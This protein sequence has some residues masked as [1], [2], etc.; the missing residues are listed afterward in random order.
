MSLNWGTYWHKSEK[1]LKQAWLITL[2]V[3]AAYIGL[4]QPFESARGI[5]EQKATGLASA[6]PSWWSPHSV[7]LR[8][9]G[10]LGGDPEF[11]FG[12]EDKSVMR[13]VISTSSLDLL[14]SDP[15]KVAAEVGRLAVSSGGYCV[16]SQTN[17]WQENAAAT[18]A[19]RVP[20][21]RFE[22]TRDLIKKLA[23]RIES[24]HIEARDVTK[25]YVDRQARLRNLQ[26]EEEQYRSILKQASNLKD[27]LA[28][29]EKL[30]EVR[31]QIE[32]DQ[33]EFAT[34]SKQTET[35]L[36]TVTLGAEDQAKVFGFHWRPLYEFKL[37]AREGLD[38]MTN[39]LAAMTRLVF[40]LP[41]TLLWLFT[42]LGGAAVGWKILRRVGRAFFGW[43]P[44]A[45]AR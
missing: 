7:A 24:E 41:S 37:A 14:V 26:A 10:T 29:T 9:E 43:K 22:Q 36:L 33:A 19:I 39:Y 23:V 6:E 13:K 38:G 31:G 27:I 25:E 18:I 3:F 4:L 44:A 42:F 8:A 16:S 1:P 32:S 17:G 2:G 35:V 20:A 15:I 45:E 34:L 28:I 40:L 21:T 11:Q 30:S 5:S 12:A